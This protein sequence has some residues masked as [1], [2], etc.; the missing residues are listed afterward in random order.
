MAKPS[1]C[2]N[3]IVKN[4]G[5][6][7]ERALASA[8]P[9]VKAVTILDT[10]SADD[11]IERIQKFCTD[12]GVSCVVASGTF[13][14]FSQARN[15][16][17]QLARVHNKGDHWCQY[18][19]LMDADME[20]VVDD[21][22]A[23]DPLFNATAASFDMIQ[24][25]GSITYGNRRI[26][27]L[28]ITRPDPYV[29]VTHEYFDIPANGMIEGA[30]FRDHA[31]GSNR[32][33]KF[34]RDARLFEDGL[35]AEPGNGRYMFYLANTYRDWG[36]HSKAIDMYKQRIALGGWDEETF[37][38]AYS[39]GLTNLEA[40]HKADGVA[41]LLAAYDFRPSRAEPLYELAK[42]YR[43]KGSSHASLLFSKKGLTVK[44]PDDLLFV[45]D[46]IYS[47]GLRYEYSVAGYY[48]EK[49]R[50]RAFQVTDDFALDP[51]SPL[52][53]RH[54]A[55]QNLFWFTKPL[56]EYCPSFVDRQIAYT[57]P[58]GY[59][60]MNPSVVCNGGHIK[61]NLRCVNYIINEHG[62]Y[63]IGEKG[64]G[65]A[66]IDTRNFLLTLDDDLNV[67]L[68]REIIWDRPQA[69][70]DMVTGLEDIRL[71]YRDGNM[72]FSAC[73][74]EQS[75][76][77]SCMQW[78]GQ[79][80]LDV[81]A[82]YML[83]MDD[84]AISPEHATEKN[85]MPISGTKEFL[86]RL[87]VV[88]TPEREGAHRRKCT[89]KVNVGDIAGSSQVIP[90]RQGY[91]CVVHEAITGP[92]SKRTYW[93]R[94]AWLDKDLILRRLSLPFVFL[95]KQIE[96]CAGLALH[97]NKRDFLISYG[98]RDAEAH[99]ATVTCEEVAAMIWQVH[100]D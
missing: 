92:D 19:L 81:D 15:D 69:K 27:N 7:I 58:P 94:F 2:L 93:H 22:K 38:A 12:N 23:F 77:G 21:P 44:R 18:V 39:L 74:R 80:K 56:R 52:D 43:E 98:V 62:Q 4:E 20:L 73:V 82:K 53:L 78:T 70:W 76:S 30:W 91:I 50:D 79:L 41:A 89:A 31:D 71:F 9:Y 25:G 51:T 32:A 85:W 88:I 68:D 10:G 5:A 55:R 14:D 17:W 36:K 54:S 63:M 37:Y 13:K 61:V 49:E 72:H 1:L 26:A 96:F 99:L 66:P 57:P 33:D 60:A 42:Y 84:H 65:D 11:T 86:Y 34:E 24:K 48:D 16:A 46:F 90:F 64:C 67:V 8:A 95:N 75:S 83:T 40:G 45:N 47:H 59:T 6:R 29:G 97:P 35:V 3:M 28:D 100:E 87:D